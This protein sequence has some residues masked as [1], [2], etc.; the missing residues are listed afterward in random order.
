MA[1][2]S[3]VNNSC[4]ILILL[5]IRGVMLYISDALQTPRINA[6]VNPL[7]FIFKQVIIMSLLST[8]LSGCW[9]KAPVNLGVKDNQLAP[10]PD[11]PN[12]VSSQ[13]TSSKHKINPIQLGENPKESFARLKQWVKQQPDTEVAKE[14]DNYLH[15][16]FRTKLMRFPDDVELLLDAENKVAH[17]RSA[18][19]IGYSDMG[20]NRKRVEAM[21]SALTP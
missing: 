7:L 10:C 16:I 13:S 1:L 3:S 11:K 15:A 9:G 8:L 19:R 4:T 2:L 12:C 20:V 6:V 18:S 17:V 14:E 5:S 21:R